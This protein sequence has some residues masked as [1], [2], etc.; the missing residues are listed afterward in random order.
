MANKLAAPGVDRTPALGTPI[1]PRRSRTEPLGTKPHTRPGDT[2][3]PHRAAATHSAH[4]ADPTAPHAQTGTRRP[5]KPAHIKQQR[6]QRHP[7][8]GAY[9]GR[10]TI[11]GYPRK[12]PPKKNNENRTLTLF[13]EKTNHKT[14]MQNINFVINPHDK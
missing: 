6:P 10:N 1:L 11:P 5:A 9:S 7:Y 8:A 3:R 4:R 14:Q 2:Q 12:P 13:S